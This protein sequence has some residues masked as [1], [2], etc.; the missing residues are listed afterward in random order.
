MAHVE[1]KRMVTEN[2]KRCGEAEGSTVTANQEG[3]DRRTFLKT[4][5]ASVA[6]ATPAV[7]LT[8]SSKA[9]PETTS[10]PAKKGEGDKAKSAGGFSRTR[11]GRLHVIM[12]GHVSRGQVP[13]LVTLVSRR[14]EVNLE[15]IGTMAVGGSAPMQR[16]T[17]FRIASVTKPVTAVAAMILVEECKIRLD[18][19]VDLWLPELTGRRVL[20]RIDG[21]LDDTVPA[22]RPIT[23]RDLLTF[24]LG[25]GAVMVFPSR[26]PIQ[27]AMEEAGIAPNANLPSLPPDELMNRYGNLPLAH[28]PGEKW[29]YN[30]GADILGVL[31]SRVAGIPLESFFHKRIFEPLGMKDTAFSV[32]AGKVDRLPPLYQ[33]DAV[34]GRLHVF[35]KAPGGKFTGPPVFESGAGG[36][37]S[38]VD[39]L[40]AFGRMMLNK[41]RYGNERILSRLAVELMTADHLTFE[42]KAVSPFFPNFWDNRG[43]GFGLSMITRRDNVADVPGRFGWDGGYGTSWYVDPREE[44]IG[45][46]MTQRLWDPGFLAMHQDFWTSAYQAIDT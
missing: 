42:Q 44:L 37:V 22:N 46:F 21:P 30:S 35:D 38:T 20:K 32:P 33:A 31:I 12:A 41:G 2:D 34:T 18:D 6:L 5:A 15:A 27:K 24:R 40:L 1:K 29:M 17:I 7:G 4:A 16:D 10:P 23:L 26:Y 11:L 45:I 36:L 25:Y 19:P 13:G 8:Q 39:D 3:F 14:G 28:Q 43:W 9:A